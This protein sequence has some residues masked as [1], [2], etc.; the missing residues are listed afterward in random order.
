MAIWSSA[1]ALAILAAY[2]LAYLALQKSLVGVPPVTVDGF[3]PEQQFFI[4]WGQV[5]GDEL[6][7]EFQRQMVTNTALSAR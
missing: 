2:V 4:A 6:R 3:T 7:P 1:K 5:R